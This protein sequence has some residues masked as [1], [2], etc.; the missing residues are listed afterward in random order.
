MAEVNGKIK[1]PMGL[2]D[3]KTFAPAAA[4]TL[5]CENMLNFFNASAAMAANMTVNFAIDGQLELGARAVVRAASDGTARSVTP[6][7]TA[8]GTAQAGVISKTFVYE[9][10]LSPGNQWVLTAARQID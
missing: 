8:I 7:G 4:V 2:A 5:V 6:T 3:V 1:W 10:E 9:F